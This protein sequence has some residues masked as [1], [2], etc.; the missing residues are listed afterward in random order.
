MDRIWFDFSPANGR[1]TIKFYAGDGSRV[2]FLTERH[3]F[4]IFH[5]DSP[6]YAVL[7]DIL[8]AWPAPWVPML[9][10]VTKVL[11]RLELKTLQENYLAH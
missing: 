5:P 11:D 7:M 10:D 3:S 8:D 9:G 2:L 6:D 1:L 4:F